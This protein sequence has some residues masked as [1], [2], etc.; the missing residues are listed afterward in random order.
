MKNSIQCPDLERLDVS[1]PLISILP[2]SAPSKESLINSSSAAAVAE[3]LALC[4]VLIASAA[5]RSEKE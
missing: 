3:A 5:E 2:A 1:F 4:F